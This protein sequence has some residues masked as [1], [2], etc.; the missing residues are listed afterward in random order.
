MYNANMRNKIHLTGSWFIRAPQKDVFNLI[1]DFE[2]MPK[3]FPKVAKEVNIVKRDG[4]KLSIQAKVK[5]F[6]RIFRL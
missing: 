2:N 6:G 4:N 1:T 3:Y 5:S